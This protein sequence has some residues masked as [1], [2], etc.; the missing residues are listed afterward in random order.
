MF[1]GVSL[2]FWILLMF[3]MLLTLLIFFVFPIFLG[4]GMF[5]AV[6]CSGPRLRWSAGLPVFDPGG[7][8]GT[9]DG[10]GIGKVLVV[11]AFV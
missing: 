3:W 9:G 8:R 11:H 6:R 10:A 7:V 2:V 4:I 5:Q 1:P